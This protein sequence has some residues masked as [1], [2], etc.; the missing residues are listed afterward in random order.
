LDILPRKRGT[1]TDETLDVSRPERLAEARGW[2]EEAAARWEDAL[3]RLKAH[4]KG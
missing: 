4:V 1:V 3:S 2:L